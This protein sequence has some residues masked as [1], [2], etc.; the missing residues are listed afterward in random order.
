MWPQSICK[1]GWEISVFRY[2]INIAVSA[3]S[4]LQQLYSFPYYFIFGW[5]KNF[6][7]MLWKN[8]NEPFGQLMYADSGSEVSVCSSPGCSA[9]PFTL[10]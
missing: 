7:K 10:T 1:G 3:S 6:R 4:K 9:V 5:P 2:V 8:L